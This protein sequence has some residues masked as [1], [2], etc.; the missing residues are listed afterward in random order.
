MGQ[1]EY[2]DLIKRVI[3]L[4]EAGI[5]TGAML[6]AIVGILVAKG[7]CTQQEFEATKQSIYECESVKRTMQQI[8]ERKAEIEELEKE[9]SRD[10][11]DLFADLFGKKGE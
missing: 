9:S 10:L 8:S 6:G 5:E 3:G 2:L 4:G 11:G 7:V 1:D